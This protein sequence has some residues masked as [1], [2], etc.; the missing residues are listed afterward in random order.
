[1][2]KQQQNVGYSQTGKNTEWAETF[3]LVF[4]NKKIKCI[5]GSFDTVTSLRMGFRG[6]R[7][8]AGLGP[9]GCIQQ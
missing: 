9:S 3:N 5:P 7:A 8:V 2:N 4:I 1:M 6:E